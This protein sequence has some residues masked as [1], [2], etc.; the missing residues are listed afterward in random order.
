ML[1]CTL[2]LLARFWYWL[3]LQAL[4]AVYLVKEQ[5]ISR[6]RSLPPYSPPPGTTIVITGGGR[7]IGRCAVERLVGLGCRVVLGCRSPEKVAP[8]FPAAGKQGG[9]VECLQ[10]DLLS[11]ASVRQF[12]QAVIALDCRVD[13]L[14]LNAGIMFGPRRE[15]EDGFESQLATNFLGHSLLTHLL[16]P[17]LAQAPEPR[18]VSVSSCAHYLGSW[19]DWADLHSASFYSQQQAYGN[20]KVAQILFSAELARRFPNVKCITL[21]PGVVYTDLYANSIFSNFLVAPLAR[22]VMKSPRQGG[23]TVVHAALDPAVVSMKDPVYLENCRPARL[24]SFARDV[25]NQGRMWDLT[26]ET[27]GIQQFG[28]ASQ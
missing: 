15:S 24:S 12:A 28:P 4:G 21:H 3:Y 20:S 10:L 16:L 27:L 13:C 25:S 7:G 2:H 17:R 8:L 1:R 19:L 5:V 18:L 11:L 26:L 9:G 14:V 22:C 23:D 6:P